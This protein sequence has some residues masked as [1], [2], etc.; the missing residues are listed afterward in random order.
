[1]N[2][3]KMPQ[4][5]QRPQ[6]RFPQPRGHFSIRSGAARVRRHGGRG[7]GVPPGE[8]PEGR[9]GAQHLRAVHGLGES[10]QG[11]DEVRKKGC[12]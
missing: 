11:V 8:A 12:A 3:I 1:M 2:Q 5:P 10:A 4:R 7:R 6:S 9:A